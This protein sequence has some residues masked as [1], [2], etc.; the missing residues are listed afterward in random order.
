MDSA[1]VRWDNTVCCA[2]IQIYENVRLAVSEEIVYLPLDERF[3]Q[4][5]V[6]KITGRSQSNLLWASL[7]ARLVASCHHQDQV[8][9]LLETTPDG[10]DKLYD[11]IIDAVAN[12]HMHEDV[13]LARI[14]L[15][16]AMYSRTPLTVE[17]LSEPYTA[18]FRLIMDLKH[19]VNHICGQLV[20]I[21]K[22]N[23]TTL[24][25]RS[26][27]EYL[28]RH[29]RQPFCLE[30]YQCHEELLGRCL[31]AICNKDLRGKIQM[32]RVLYFLR[33]AATSRAFHLENCKVQS[34]RVLNGLTRFSRGPFTRS[35]IQY[36]ATNGPLSQYIWL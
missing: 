22:S 6:N 4:D 31:M 18:E 36:M 11:R 13:Q 12:L 16:W 34:D 21:N 32:L 7:V 20:T 1:R 9:R 29:A 19:T 3:K 14:L 33:H 2:I 10:M 25:H 35:W 26:A 24:V 8:E 15:S 5:I 30:I 23:Q 17:E 28:R 27:R